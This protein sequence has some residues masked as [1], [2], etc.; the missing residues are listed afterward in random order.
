[1]TPDEWRTVPKGRIQHASVQLSSCL[2]K[3][4]CAENLTVMAGQPAQDRLLSQVCVLSGPPPSL[5]L[6]KGLH[7]LV[8]GARLSASFCVGFPDRDAISAGQSAH[9]EEF[10]C[11]PVARSTP[12]SCGALPTPRGSGPAA[13]LRD[14][15]ALPLRNRRAPMMPLTQPVRGSDCLGWRYPCCGKDGRVRLEPWPTLAAPA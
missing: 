3:A 13:P 6:S 1:M 12:S 4:F 15:T 10:L 5:G 8:H 14:R 2:R 9:F 11:G 7:E